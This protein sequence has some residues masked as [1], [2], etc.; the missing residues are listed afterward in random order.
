M[1][2]QPTASARDVITIPEPPPK[3]PSW[4]TVRPAET[5]ENVAFVS[6]AA[7]AT[8][9]TALMHDTLPAALLANRLALKAAAVIS[10][11]EG[12]MANEAEIRDAWHLTRPDVDGE[13]HWG[14]DGDVLEFWRTAVRL[15][16][17]AHGWRTQLAGIAAAGSEDLVA[18][19]IDRGLDE[20][21]RSGPPAA[22]VGIMGRVLDADDR[23]ERIACLAADIVLAKF[24]RWGRPLPL[25]A[26]HL[27]KAM[28]RDL[29]GLRDLRARPA[30]GDA[31][32]AIRAALAESA[33]SAFLLASDLAARAVALRSA[34]PKLRAR[35]A[36]E[37][38]ALFLTEDAVA[39][40]TMLSPHIRGTA[41]PMTARAARRFCDRLVELGVARELTGRPTFRLYGL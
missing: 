2:R 4:V 24:F 29:R 20:A 3:L 14:P 10:K 28:L 41:T 17:N 31:E 35:G 25:T 8:L 27:D 38:V 5:A 1:T 15:R 36:H 32:F 39:P 13:R 34:A 37:A 30:P 16:L 21:R 11:L 22:A 33:R 19:E 40:S 18:G 9:D 6:G 7:F 12:R 23:A 26:L